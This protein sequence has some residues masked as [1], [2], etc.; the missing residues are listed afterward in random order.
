MIT[1]HVSTAWG[2]GGL[3]LLGLAGLCADLLVVLALGESLATCGSTDL[4]LL[5]LACVDL[6]QA[7][8]N[9]A[10]LVLDGLPRALL[11]DLLSDTLLVHPSEEDGPGDLSRVLALVEER[12]GLA[13]VEAESLAVAAD[14]QLTLATVDVVHSQPDVPPLRLVVRPVCPS[15]SVSKFWLLGRSKTA[16]YS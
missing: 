9:N 6:L 1:T 7:G 3:G 4:R 8:T 11:G 16:L 5:V 15:I 12:L 13:A 10:T 2:G 14:V